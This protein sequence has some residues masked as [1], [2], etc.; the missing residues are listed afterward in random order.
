MT[1]RNKALL[2]GALIGALTGLGAAVLYIRS[3]E[4]TGSDEPD[5]IATGDAIMLAVSVFNI[6]KQ[7]A[8]LAD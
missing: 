6:I 1:W 5:K 3:V 2:I 7:V 4:D 8:K